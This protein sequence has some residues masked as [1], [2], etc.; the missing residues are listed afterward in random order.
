MIKKIILTLLIIAG[1]TL[2]Q[3]NQSV[4]LPNFVI[5]GIRSVDIKT[6]NKK[7]PDLISTLSKEFI[8]PT[9]T[10][11]AFKI[12]ILS[13]ISV[14][15]TNINFV[16]RD[17]NGFLNV[18]VGINTLPV[19]NLRYTLSSRHVMLNAKVWGSNDREFI[20]N[21][22]YN[23][24][25]VSVNSDFFVSGSSSFLP[26]L[27]VSLKTGFERDDY[28][29]YGSATPT[30]ER[31][32]KNLYG[33]A[34]LVHNL[35]G[36]NFG[37]E[38]SG[39]AYELENIKLEEKYFNAKAFVE[40]N[41]SRFAVKAS[42]EYKKQD[43]TNNLSLTDNYDYLSGNAYAK[44][45]LSEKI[46]VKGGVNYSKA[47]DLNL[48]SI[49]AGIK[50]KLSKEVS[51]Y[52]EYNPGAD[53]F[54]IYDFVKKNKYFNLGTTDNLFTK[55]K[56]RFNA[57]LKYEYEKYVEAGVSVDYSKSDN[58][59]FFDD[60]A[61]KGKF[62]L[63]TADDIQIISGGVYTLFH[64]GPMGKFYGS[65]NFSQATFSNDDKV[66]YHP[67]FSGQLNYS[68]LTRIGLEINPK[69]KLYSGAYTDIANKNK[70]DT[71][72][73]LGV[74]FKYMLLKNLAATLEIN[75]IANSKNY[76][77]NGY[78]EKPMDIILGIDYRW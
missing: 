53:F 10:P 66:P 48:F 15:D 67:T 36:Y 47:D 78:E 74:K 31:K 19:G 51:L 38:L 3:N 18:G 6:L 8:L 5:T 16:N 33:G 27:R 44:L 49:Y 43:L 73:D 71:Y 61:A 32:S 24:S 59:G 56:T 37:L 26:G 63:K 60:A 57:T 9:K 22:G 13:N 4:E 45:A 12:S 21:A 35:G 2:A 65:L 30:Q 11:D 70:L 34:E 1:C 23:T 39:R 7:M 54:T 69:L 29:F 72:I 62:D 77:F 50:M 14:P 25:G 55:H 40:F 42:A 76:I 52:G 58:Y 17:Y 46:S 28:K 64:L 75:N 41:V 68:Y 20:D